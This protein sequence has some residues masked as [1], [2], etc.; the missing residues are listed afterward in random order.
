MQT[1]M[2]PLRSMS[3]NTPK[4]AGLVGQE[5]IDSNGES[6]MG[7]MM[8][9][10]PPRSRPPLFPIQETVH[11]SLFNENHSA[12]PPCTPKA[13]PDPSTPRS[14]GKLPGKVTSGVHGQARFDNEDT[15]GS[16]TPEKTVVS[17]TIPGGN[18]KSKFLWFQH[19]QR[20]NSSTVADPLCSSKARRPPL[21]PDAVPQGDC[22][23]S[24]FNSPARTPRQASSSEAPQS[25]KAVGN[26]QDKTPRGTKT[27][28]RS[29]Q[30]ITESGQ[31]LNTTPKKSVSRALKYVQPNVGGGSASA[32]SQ[33]TSSV[34]SMALFQ[35]KG[36]MVSSQSA[37][38]PQIEAHFELEEDLS[39]WRDHNVQV[40]I[41]T[42]PLSSSEISVQGF[43]R[44]IRQDSAHSVTWTGH[45]ESRFTFD[46]VACESITQER[47][48]KVAGLPMVENCMSGY[49]SCI[50][51]YGQTGSGKTHTMLG[52]I[53]DLD[54][55]PSED[56]GMTPRVFEYL[57][58][59][60]QMEEEARRGEHLKYVCKCSFLEI[61]NEQITDLLDPS[62]TNL[63]LREDVKKGVYVDNLKEVEVTGVH[64]VL[65]L[66]LQGAANRKVAAT[67]MNRESSRSHSV[68]TCVIESKWER[69]SVINT[70][71]GR[72]NLVDLAGSE[73][74]KTSGAEG[75]RLREA[76]NIN[77]SLSTLGLV[78]M[79]LVD[80]ANGKQRHVPYRDS[81]LTFL[82]QD[83]LG[84]NSKTMIIATVSPSNFCSLETLSTLKF[85]QR[86][87]FIQNNAV[88]NE[89]T[90][91]DVLALRQQIQLL[92]DELNIMKRQYERRS[93]SFHEPF[94]LESS[95]GNALDLVETGNGLRLSQQSNKAVRELEAVLAGS[96]RR[97]Q[98]AENTTKRLAA[99]IEQ[100]DSLVRQREDDTQCGKMMLRFREDKIRRLESL[101]DGLLSAD[102]HLKAEK[103][104]LVEELQLVRSKVDRNPELTRFAM[105]NIRLM[106]QLRRFQDFYDGGERETMAEEISNLR[107][108]LLEL[109]DESLVDDGYDL[110][111]LT[112]PQ[113][114]V[115]VPELAAAARENELLRNEADNY[116]KEMKECRHNL[117]SCLEEN[118]ALMRQVDDLQMKIT[119]LKQ[120]CVTQQNELHDWST[121]AESIESVHKCHLEMIASLRAELQKAEEK[122]QLEIKTRES[123][124]QDL[125]EA[126][127]T[128]ENFQAELQSVEQDRAITE[129]SMSNCVVEVPDSQA[130]QS[131]EEGINYS[132]ETAIQENGIANEQ[133]ITRLQKEL[134]NLYCALE[135]EQRHRL[136]LENTNNSIEK[137]LKESNF[138]FQQEKAVVQ[139]LEDQQLFSL[140]EIESLLEQNNKLSENLNRM[141]EKERVVKRQVHC[142][143][144]K[145]KEHELQKL[146]TET[147]LKIEEEKAKGDYNN[148]LERTNLELQLE[149]TKKDLEEAKTLN[150]TI[151]QEQAWRFAVEKEMDVTRTE[152]ATETAN[153]IANIHSELLLVKEESA[154]YSEQEKK[155]REQVE[156]LNK[157]IIELKLELRTALLEKS[158]S[159][160]ASES[161][162]QEKEMDIHK[163]RSQYEAAT[164]QLLDFL[165]EGHQALNDAAIEMEDIVAGSF[166]DSSISE[167][168]QHLQKVALRLS[169]KQRVI[170][171]L[172]KKLQQ[173]FNI[174]LTTETKFMEL[175]EESLA[176][177]ELQK[178]EN[179]KMHSELLKMTI[180]LEEKLLRIDSLQ[181]EIKFCHDQI[182]NAEKKASA[183]FVIVKELQNSVAICKTLESETRAEMESKLKEAE[184]KTNA[185][186]VV[187][188]MLSER[189]EE[190]KRMGKCA[191]Y[192]LQYILE[193][194]EKKAIGAFILIQS[195]SEALEKSKAL[196][197][198]MQEDLERTKHDKEGLICFKAAAENQ[199]ES[200]TLKLQ[201]SEAASV[202][203]EQQLAFLEREVQRLTDALSAIEAQ[204]LDA[205]TEWRNDKNMILLALN[206][207]KLD[208]AEKASEAAALLKKFEDG[209][210]TLREAELLLNA[211]I[212]ANETAKCDAQGWKDEKDRL[213][214]L[215]L[216]WMP[217]RD[218]FNAEV[219]R[220]EEELSSMKKDLEAATVDMMSLLTFA[221]QEMRAT[222]SCAAGQIETAE[223]DLYSMCKELQL[224]LE[225]MAF[226]S[227]QFKH[228]LVKYKEDAEKDK[229]ASLSEMGALKQE[230]EY[231]RYLLT[232][233]ADEVLN[234][235]SKTTELELLAN[236]NGQLS[237]AGCKE[238]M[239]NCKK[240]ASPKESQDVENESI[241][242]QN[243]HSITS[244]ENLRDEIEKLKIMSVEKEELLCILMKFFEDFHMVAV[245]SDKDMHILGSEIFSLK[246]T[247]LLG[248]E[249]LNFFSV[250]T[251]NAV[252]ENL[253][254]RCAVLDR[255]PILQEDTICEQAAVTIEIGVLEEY[256]MAAEARL[257]IAESNDTELAVSQSCIDALRKNDDEK[258]CRLQQLQ[259]ELEM[260]HVRIAELD[261]QCRDALKASADKAKEVEELLYKIDSLKDEKLD[262]AN[263]IETLKAA[264]VEIQASYL[265]NSHAHASQLEKLEEEL[266]NLKMVLIE[267]DREVQLMEEVHQRELFDIML[268][269]EEGKIAASEMMTGLDHQITRIV[270]QVSEI[271]VEAKIGMQELR[272]SLED[273]KTT[274]QETITQRV[275][276]CR[277]D[278]TLLK[279]E[280]TS[281]EDTKNA[282]ICVLKDRLK[283]A[284]AK[285]L[286]AD[287][288][289]AEMSAIK[290]ELEKVLAADAQT[291][292]II[293]NLEEKLGECDRRMRKLDDICLIINSKFEKK[294]EE[295]E[296]MTME[297]ETTAV[298][299]MRL[300]LECRD[301]ISR[302]AQYHDDEIREI[303]VS[304][305]ALH[306]DISLALETFKFEFTTY[307]DVLLRDKEIVQKNL[308]GCMHQLEGDKISLSVAKSN[309]SV[310]RRL[311][312]ELNESCEA[313]T[314]AQ[315]AESQLVK[316][317]HEKEKAVVQLRLAHDYYSQ[318]VG[319]L[320]GENICLKERLSQQEAALQKVQEEIKIQQ[321]LQ[322]RE[323]VSAC[324]TVFF[325]DE[326]E[327]LKIKFAVRKEQ[328]RN[329]SFSIETSIVKE[330]DSLHTNMNKVDEDMEY[331]MLDMTALG[332][333]VSFGLDQLRVTWGQFRTA[334]DEHVQ[335]L[336]IAL[337]DIATSQENL[338]Q[339]RVAHKVEMSILQE[340]LQAAEDKLSLANTQKVDME[341]E[342]LLIQSTVSDLLVSNTDKT[343]TIET[344]K[345]ALNE[346]HNKIAHL[347]LLYSE[348]LHKLENK[349]MEV[350]EQVSTTNRLQKEIEDSKNLFGE[351]QT[352]YFEACDEVED[353]RN[354]LAT[355]MSTLQSYSD[356][357]HQLEKENLELIDESQ[358][359]R[360]AFVEHEDKLRVSAEEIQHLTKECELR[361][362][363]FN[364]TNILYME[365]CQEH[366][367]KKDEL[368]QT[369]LRLQLSNDY[370]TQLQ[371][372]NLDL[373]DELKQSRMVLAADVHEKTLNLTSLQEEQQES[374][375]KFAEMQ[376]LYTEVCQQHSDLE[377]DLARITLR[378][379]QCN[380]DNTQ[381]EKEKLE[382]VDELGSMKVNLA[383]Y[384]NKENEF[385]AKLEEKDKHLGDIV[386]RVKDLEKQL[387]QTGEHNAT[388]QSSS[389]E[390]SVEK[391]QCLSQE[392][393]LIQERFNNMN[394]LYLDV[395]KEHEEKKDEL[396]QALLR[397]QLC[398]DFMT[399]LQKKNLELSDELKQLRMVA[400]K[401]DQKEKD[402][403]ENTLQLTNLEEELQKSHA[404]IAE[405][406][407][408]YAGVCQ[409]QS[410]LENELGRISL[411]LQQ[412]NEYNSHL[413]KEKLELADELVAIKVNL[414]YHT[415]NE[416]EFAAKLEEKDKHLGDFVEQVKGLEK[417]LQQTEENNAK[418][419]S[420]YSDVCKQLA[421]TENQSA[422]VTM[423]LQNSSE[424]LSQLESEK[425]QL[426]NELQ[427]LREAVV[428]LEV[429]EQEASE[430]A[431]KITELQD[432]LQQSEGRSDELHC[433]YL[434]ACKE[435][436][437]KQN[438][439]YQ[440]MC[441]LQIVKDSATVL[442]NEK[443]ELAGE[444]HDI[445]VAMSQLEL[446]NNEAEENLSIM[447]NE[448]QKNLEKYEELQDL[449]S[450]V[451]K[452]LDDKR[453]QLGLVM[454]DLQLCNHNATQLVEENL[455]LTEQLEKSTE[456]LLQ[457]QEKLLIRETIRE[458][459]ELATTWQDCTARIQHDKEV[460]CSNVTALEER[461]RLSLQSETDL[462]ASAER[463]ELEL[464]NFRSELAKLLAIDQD[465]STNICML[466]KE[467]K[468]CQLQNLDLQNRCTD[469]RQEL[470]SKD[471]MINKLLSEI[472]DLKLQM[473]FLANENSSKVSQLQQELENGYK[474]NAEI[475]SQLQTLQAE[476]LKSE[477]KAVVATCN[478]GKMEEFHTARLQDEIDRKNQLIK[479]LEFDIRLLQESSVKEMQQKHSGHESRKS[480]EQLGSEIDG[481]RTD[482]RKMEKKLKD[483]EHE[484]QKEKEIVILL[485]DEIMTL[486]ENAAAVS[487]ESINSESLFDELQSKN[488]C[489]EEELDSTRHIVETL[490]VE[491]LDVSSLVEQKIAQSLQS[492]KQE[493]T[494]VTRERDQLHA[495]LLV[496]NEQLEMA[497]A[498]LEE[499][500]LVAAEAR[501]VAEMSKTHA[502]EK[503]AEV[504][505]LEKSVEELES[506][507]NALENQVGMGKREAE[508]QRLA[509]ED[510]EMELQSLT[511]RLSTNMQSAH[512]IGTDSE[513]I[514][515]DW[516]GNARRVETERK[517][518]EKDRQLMEVAMM[519]DNLNKEVGE[520]D[521][522]IKACKAHILE[523]KTIADRQ[524]AEHI[525]KIKS[526]ESLVEQGKLIQE[527]SYN[528]PSTPHKSA[529]KSTSKSKGSGSPFKCIGL[530]LAQQMN[531][532]MDE[533]LLSN[534]RRI[535]ELERIAAARQ[536]EVFML[537]AKL[538]EAESMTHD[539]VRDL[540]GVK[541]DITNY[542]SML[543]QQEALQQA[544]KNRRQM[545]EAE[546]KEEVSLVKAQLDQLIAERESWLEEINRRQAEMVTARVAAEKLR[547]RDHMLTDENEKLK[548][549]NSICKKQVTEIEAELNKLSGQQNLQQ[550]I[551]HHA[552][553]KD[554]N[555]ILRTQLDELRARLRKTEVVLG[556]VSDELARYRTAEGKSPHI[557]V[558]EEQRLRNKLQEAE[559]DR[560]Q[561]AQKLTR[562]CTRVMQAA[563]M[564]STRD[565]DVS[566][567]LDALDQMRNRLEQTEQELSDLKLKSKIAGEKRRLS[568][569]RALHSPCKTGILSSPFKSAMRN[570]VASPV[571]HSIER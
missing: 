19:Q 565:V 49:N 353:I 322:E 95:I 560:M 523:L 383:S 223:A 445:E 365:I 396:A 108:R 303:M 199:L 70:R 436:E 433:L 567:S 392:C 343:L 378:L 266:H 504:K 473:E 501:Q 304:V 275:E 465:R 137:E 247:M 441:N 72:L 484:L 48:F 52:D 186:F 425:L 246:Q 50:F 46:H 546:A 541:M 458:N 116:Q 73:R 119:G 78:I 526:M 212:Q 33:Q 262:M 185:A 354:E 210:A 455:Q 58:V 448:L 326:V 103:E 205:E 483:I 393:E 475:R 51:A 105:E 62:S 381:L 164:S 256:L 147:K 327:T 296:L 286:V 209:K 107:D 341:S 344:L 482:G 234:L 551:H 317:L 402:L 414:A 305:T 84:G 150:S 548:A 206:E 547:L 235:Q 126:L 449:Y 166:P 240:I 289:E 171:M 442:E 488:K 25:T 295:I 146:E 216:A 172:Q 168:E 476:N 3:R 570:A 198:E 143:K 12:E 452:E 68:F 302:M 176:M 6:A 310:L 231:V 376:N 507:V 553:I 215:A 416:K 179:E 569:L 227:Q 312:Y 241:H 332:K 375:S 11:K 489:L 276:A 515:E 403:A 174:A 284:E 133:D 429:K 566:A 440:V 544:D 67:N 102:D 242:L 7:S 485:R 459:E 181:T 236:G 467:I 264:E 214:S 385:T 203:K 464:S 123:L 270:L 460:Q 508:M 76:A 39:F 390:D 494:L 156:N 428:Q 31:Q 453:Q 36:G 379:Q 56:R 450:G 93:F 359:L 413:E 461:L 130:Q 395:C 311:R 564:T 498:I 401:F 83:S 81:K 288:M 257:C 112:T 219:K 543:N 104:A 447:Q 37:L 195:F 243:V 99:Q 336:D 360:S 111:A 331:L 129:S 261:L 451:C 525:R 420:L 339:F 106:E 554:E 340:A 89:D 90:S 357:L 153:A 189:A 200:L 517:L 45:P 550:R 27:E 533:E 159:I 432:E 218:S 426:V 283:A 196:E 125:K 280:L 69:E 352:L 269:L 263:K 409:Q 152:A 26:A 8:S 148:S 384:E 415:N 75:D 446:T 347:Q 211:L 204:L 301:E 86:A 287:S 265:Q 167:K 24:D 423:N 542:A 372:E 113:K 337:C 540:L 527:K 480:V 439:L 456:D 366:K 370:S 549:E 64:D 190:S 92:K 35:P 368:A 397:L 374:H 321:H 217:E 44:C 118:A 437:D 279:Q 290:A 208:S 16:G 477:E 545:E 371:K 532:E 328:F 53:H 41:R 94:K 557:D 299:I 82:L 254:E 177:A 334:Y 510:L 400:A 149:Q 463:H 503:E 273:I 59:R 249:E 519:V 377:D 430:K 516:D 408:L 424:C 282:E 493:L 88:V 9:S 292:T 252:H 568:E 29:V 338:M 135:E 114:Q 221:R 471:V 348:S 495:E 207:A 528:L 388:V 117:N 318:L 491:L 511:H 239:A 63:Q 468:H 225:H 505:L 351:L 258:S 188:R 124:E 197:N 66:L 552:K 101:A 329:D 427:K 136:E 361:Q 481:Y 502:E 202:E 529:E 520:K 232:Q 325:K 487:R 43:G 140:N 524:A 492:L 238:V 345:E 300:I 512:E 472:E 474:T 499:R 571:A 55:K 405:M 23:S 293:C 187:A 34:R 220:K 358:K 319:E 431:T 142:L 278:D 518:Q 127:L 315:N 486:R 20:Q 410:G 530:G 522:Q 74:Q 531:S 509:K 373:S 60:I 54:Q 80:V 170:E 324:K 538:A 316:E 61:Y 404:E 346:S 5:H 412:C 224:G 559:D 79:I 138:N 291:S 182:R 419:Q 91:G 191:I 131:D 201:N 163:L 462:L 98:A 355:A 418:I 192:D 260:K 521:A 244:V 28:G 443:A 18:L 122:A 386:K 496:V 514:D 38:Q 342:L 160:N 535:E 237:A 85:A 157:K 490:E 356:N 47:L 154:T 32:G 230:L 435:L 175:R 120:T 399:Q 466:E 391:M 556:R 4:R 17:S 21:K 281:S 233:S 110:T 109:L 394:N 139:A 561:I 434:G 184:R 40:L 15:S 444:L 307:K 141:E 363:N 294:E 320:E 422:V 173:A 563:G 537:N 411:Q 323:R 145:L 272:T 42:R 350:S 367:E 330:L 255:F 134:A 213:N 298:D 71:F 57:F 558:D 306:K 178:K 285:L 457:L 470:Q 417:Q 228:Q 251:K 506:T 161:L 65:Q 165:N 382:L 536:K 534:K 253:Q 469:A 271:Q 500:E 479:G 13:K 96:L 539:V 22:A 364:N 229:E 497:H 245:D 169:E 97:E 77:K 309:E 222:I 380:E 162:L 2:S 158:T 132:E 226:I 313:L 151:Q 387:Q 194:T 454:S 478:Q 267:K 248:L 259:K 87:K 30:S 562:L 100:L 268:T 183:A 115:L 421:E 155:A 14:K 335:T 180:S 333:D 369:L 10:S 250:Q 513:T 308:P 1:G 193:E 128:A 362:E 406:Q 389:A 314:E 277:Q 555:R 144:W 398:N 438:E 407:N 297:F 121:K 349:E 274:A